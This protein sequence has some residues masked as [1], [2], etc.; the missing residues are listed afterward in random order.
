MR[1][2]WGCDAHRFG[3][4]GRTLLGGV[5]ADDA[6]GVEA[7]SDGDVLAHAV[8]DALLGAAAL[9]DLGAL[10]PSSDPRWQRADSM[11]LVAEVMARVVA[12]GYR[13]SSVDAT[14]IAERVRVSPHREAIRARLAAVLQMDAAAVSVKG[15]STDG[16]G[17]LGRDEGLAA[18]V[19]AVLE[20]V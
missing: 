2:G 8:A 9:G 18:V 1:V 5:V 15:T 17:F 6:R 10:F 3:G 4:P 11:A 19:V 14:V 7:T 12:A 16:L 13:V 20:P